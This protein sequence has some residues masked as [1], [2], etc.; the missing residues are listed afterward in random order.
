MRIRERSPV[1]DVAESAQTEKA[2]P[3]LVFFHA[4]RSGRC[5]RVEAM[6]AHT[7]VRRH[8][9]DT[10]VLYRVDVE[11]RPELAAHF[12]VEDVPTLFVIEGRRASARLE[13]AKGRAS[14]QIEAFLAPWLK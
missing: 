4:G 9:H 5:R 12:Q 11:E 10:F 2:K 7:L 6:L 3:W 8:N 1:A 13:L 14:R